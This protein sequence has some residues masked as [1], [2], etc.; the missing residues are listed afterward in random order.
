[1]KPPDPCKSQTLV[2]AVEVALSPASIEMAPVRENCEEFGK[3]TRPVEPLSETP[4]ARAAPRLTPY[5]N[6][7]EVS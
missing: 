4:S 7:A 2:T 6:A 5:I 3:A 1:V